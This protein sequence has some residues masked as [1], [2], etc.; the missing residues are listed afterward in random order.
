MG[1][2]LDAF[3]T[4]SDDFGQ[5]GINQLLNAMSDPTR[6][7]VQGLNAALAVVAGIEARNEAEA[8]LGIQ[9]AATHEAA[10]K[11]L[12][13]AASGSDPKTTEV[14]GNLATKLLRTYT[15]QI[16]ALA[17][18]KRGGEQTVRVEHV[19]VHAGGQA[20][21]GNVS[22]GQGGG[23]RYSETNPMHSVERQPLPFRSALRCG[24]VSPHRSGPP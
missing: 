18:L 3:A 2:V 12:R 20:I 1:M 13:V 22:T 14:Y 17:K 15:A 21:V 16:E 19:H 10:M 5:L 4:T 8:Q 23:V 24:V 7:A 6:S 11:M 9:M